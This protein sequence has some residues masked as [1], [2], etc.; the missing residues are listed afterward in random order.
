MWE[1]I[2]VWEE[3]SKM[4]GSS[5][6]ESI[7]HTWSFWVFCV[8]WLWV[9]VPEEK[10]TAAKYFSALQRWTPHSSNPRIVQTLCCHRENLSFIK[11]V[12]LLSPFFPSPPYLVLAW[13]IEIMKVKLINLSVCVC[14][15]INVI[16]ITYC[17]G[18]AHDR[19]SDLWLDITVTKEKIKLFLRNLMAYDG[20]RMYK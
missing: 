2:T 10:F 19:T 3:C 1:I 4:S 17:Y 8:Y 7:L 18:G 6:N 11:H 20:N 9:S 12:A 15:C 13:D 5:G 14:V 16:D